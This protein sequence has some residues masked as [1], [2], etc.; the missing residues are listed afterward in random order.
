MSCFSLGSLRI[1]AKQYNK[2]YGKTIQSIRKKNKC[3]LFRDLNNTTETIEFCKLPK[4]EY[5]KITNQDIEF[6]FSQC[7]KKDPGFSYI[8]VDDINK[9]DINKIKN[10]DK[11]L[12]NIG[13][14]AETETETELNLIY[15]NNAN[16]EIYFFIGG[17]KIPNRIWNLKKKYETFVK[18][19]TRNFNKFDV[20][21]FLYFDLLMDLNKF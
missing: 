2:E 4:G 5:S 15:V 11:L 18:I 20:I 10:H 19:D 9:Y 16:R 17:K 12:I 14:R 13:A 8:H 3:E 6:I 7:R 21:Y 1:I